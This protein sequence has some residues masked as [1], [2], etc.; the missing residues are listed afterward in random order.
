MIIALVILIICE[1]IGLYFWNIVR[2]ART[3]M[4]AEVTSGKTL[5]NIIAIVSILISI[6]FYL[7]S[8]LHSFSLFYALILVINVGVLFADRFEKPWGYLAYLIFNGAVIFL[9]FILIFVLIYI[10]FYPPEFVVKQF[11]KNPIL[12]EGT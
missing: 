11:D 5:A 1:L 7:L 6:P 10:A 2:K 12:K 9:G 8:P 3:Y 4:I